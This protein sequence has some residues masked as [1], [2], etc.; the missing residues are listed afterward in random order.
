VDASPD[1]LSEL[2]TILQTEGYQVLSSSTM[3]DAR[4]FLKSANIV[5][6]GPNPVMVGETP[7]SDELRKLAPN[8]PVVAVAEQSDRAAMASE[9]LQAVK[10]A[11]ADSRPPAG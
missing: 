6:F 9:L 1:M 4:L 7:S 11:S 5:V 2:R 10:A 3:D 8:L